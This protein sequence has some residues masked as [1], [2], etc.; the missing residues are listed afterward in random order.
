LPN[1]QQF[2]PDKTLNKEIGLRTQWFDRHLTINADVYYIDW[3]DVQVAGITQFGAV[4]IT[5]NGAKAVSKGVELS[6]Q[7]VLPH[8]FGVTANYTYTNA[9]LTQDVKGLVDDANTLSGS[10]DGCNPAKAA[11]ATIGSC[12]GDAL[13]GDRL[14]GSP[15]H[16]GAVYASWTHALPNDAIFRLDYGVAVQSNVFT[17]VGNRASGEALGGFS[18]HQMALSFEKDNWTV[19]VFGQNIWNT[20]AA[21][22]VTQDKSFN[23]TVLG[24]TAADPTAFALRRYA[25]TIIRPREVGLEF[26]MK[27]G[28]Q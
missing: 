19:G 16:K 13:S 15:E 12:P 14:P 20:Y 18:T 28:G 17:K 24:G 23:Y 1:E 5:T 26:R 4:G 25:R 22:A 7:G 11:Y 10:I 8:G 27:F 6:L 9:K 2:L 3:K 21:T